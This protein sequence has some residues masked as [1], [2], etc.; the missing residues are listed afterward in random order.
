MEFI[1]NGSLK[2]HTISGHGSSKAKCDMCEKS[3]SNQGNM[4]VHMFQ[5]HVALNRYKCDQC[6]MDF[7]L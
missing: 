2:K 7:A 6:E 1:N 4:E 5:L 3:F